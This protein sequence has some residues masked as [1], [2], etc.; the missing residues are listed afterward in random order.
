MYFIKTNQ[1]KGTAIKTEVIFGPVPI[2]S[3]YYLQEYI[4]LQKRYKNL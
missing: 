3:R 2:T 1:H 4:M